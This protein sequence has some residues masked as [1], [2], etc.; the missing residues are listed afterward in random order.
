MCVLSC[1][2]FG[3]DYS[4]ALDYAAAIEHIQNL[5]LIHDDIEDGDDERR[6][7]PALW[8]KY[9]IPH[10]VNIGDTFVPLATLSIIRS[11]YPDRVKLRLMDTVASFGMEMAAGQALDISLRSREFVSVTDYMTCTKFKTGSFLAMAVV[12]GGIVGGAAA[13]HLDSLRDYAHTA[14]VAFQ[15]KDDCLDISGGKGRALG[16]DIREGK[17]T[18]HAVYAMNNANSV[19]RDRLRCILRKRRESTTAADIDWVMR[20]YRDSGAIE[21]A[22]RTSASLIEASLRHLLRLPAGAAREKLILLSRYLAQRAR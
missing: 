11:L 13:A 9:G 10:A 17:I 6:S 22:R 8:K 20:L 14:G 2:I 21:F 19:D 16:S 3:V 12:G 18:A 1:E 4:R 5:T 7:L 15:V